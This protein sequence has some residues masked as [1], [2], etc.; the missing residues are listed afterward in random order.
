MVFFVDFEK[1]F[2]TIEWSF[3]LKALSEFN[4]G[5]I[6]IK[7]I[8]ILYCNISSCVVNNGTSCKYFSVKRGVRQGDPLSPY[9]FLVIEMLAIKI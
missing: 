2:D 5:E 4:F 6:L 9:L 3:M 1:A 7:W 8:K